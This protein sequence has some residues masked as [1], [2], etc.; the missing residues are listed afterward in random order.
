MKQKY[1]EDIINP[2]QL[3]KVKEKIC[4]TKLALYGN[5]TYT[6]YEKMMQTCLEKY[7]VKNVSYSKEI[8]DKKR[9]TFFE[10]FNTP[11]KMNNLI[12]QRKNMFGKIWCKKLFLN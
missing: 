3:T 1:G 10:H 4:K 6:N 5:E 8:N 7:G 2:F 9:K 12:L 11:E